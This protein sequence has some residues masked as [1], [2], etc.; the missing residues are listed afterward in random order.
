MPNGYNRGRDDV[1]SR[2]AGN[3]TLPSPI[4]AGATFSG[5]TSY[6]GWTYTTDVAYVSGLL[7]NTS[8]TFSFSPRCYAHR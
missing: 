8:G 5:S 7:N 1:V 4:S 6:A 2:A 3:V